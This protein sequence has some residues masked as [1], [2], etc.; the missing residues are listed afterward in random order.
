V[1]VVPLLEADVSA[2][3]A[4]LLGVLQGI[5]EWLPVSSEGVV[6]ATY[7]AFRS[8]SFDD[9]V[10]LALWLH[11]GT[12]VSALVALRTEVRDVVKDLAI[13]WRSGPSSLT[14]QLLLATIVSG[15]VGLPMLL[16][17]QEVSDRF[18]ASAMGLIG[19]LMLITGAV[20]LRRHAVGTRGAADLSSVDGILAGIA[21]GVA[22]LPGLSRSGSTV[23]VLLGRRIERQDAL[24][25]SF[26]MSIPASFGAALYAGVDSGLALSSGALVASIIACVVGLMTIRGLLVVAQRVNFGLFVLL[27]GAIMLG[28][29]VWQALT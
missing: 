16:A 14:R 21:Q 1:S 29:G 15:V 23:A 22:V 4:L 5:S 28:S 2:P 3:L 19:A 10:T 6:A 26:L 13:H 18:G 9:A 11:I 24:V 7:A 12:S 27:V 25:F 8:G 17:L 20:Q